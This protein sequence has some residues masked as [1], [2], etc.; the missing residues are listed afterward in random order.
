M[1]PGVESERGPAWLLLMGLC[2][3]FCAVG[4]G[5]LELPRSEHEFYQKT[6]VASEHWAREGASVRVPAHMPSPSWAAALSAP[7]AGPHHEARVPRLLQMNDGLPLLRSDP[8][9][10]CAGSKQ[11]RPAQGAG[12][13]RT[14]GVQVPIRER[15]YA[16]VGPGGELWG[17]RELPSPL[18][19][20]VGCV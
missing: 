1:R 4:L 7:C 14:L 18:L 15:G 10:R 8:G 2:C 20:G 16:G 17:M 5:A 11:L 6:A 12:F 9:A 19:N 13:L 3:A